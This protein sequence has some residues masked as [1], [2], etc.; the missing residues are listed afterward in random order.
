MDTKSANKG[1]AFVEPATIG[2]HDSSN[3]ENNPRGFR[4]GV[5]FFVMFSGGAVQF[6]GGND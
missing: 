6:I 1:D 3:A 5:D 2:G 4:V